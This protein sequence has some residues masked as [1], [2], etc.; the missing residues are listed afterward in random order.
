MMSKLSKL[1]AMLANARELGV[2]LGVDVYKQTDRL[3]EEII[4]KEI[5][6]VIKDQIEPTL[7]HIKRI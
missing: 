1:Y 6:P 5:I 4:K 7:R 3:E 2:D